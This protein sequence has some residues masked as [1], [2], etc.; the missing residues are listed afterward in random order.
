MRHRKSGRKLNRNSSHRKALFKNLS[1]ALIQHEIIKT[2]LPKA[3]ELRRFLE[4][5]V[6][7]AKVASVAN[8]RFVFSKL[9]SKHSLEKLFDVIAPACQGRPGGYLRIIKAGYRVGDTA[10]VAY[11]EFVDRSSF[12][13]QSDQVASPAASSGALKKKEQDVGSDSHAV[14]AE[15]V[16]VDSAK[17]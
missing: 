13:V 6:T 9:R 15:G 14:S 5:L 7:T 10:P 1:I 11:I 16:G 12:V 4:P 17:A 3:K 8:R 2:T